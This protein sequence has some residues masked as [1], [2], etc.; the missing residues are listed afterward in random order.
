MHLSAAW[1][2]YSDVAPLHCSTAIGSAAVLLGEL[3]QLGNP[4]V[5]DTPTSYTAPMM[6]CPACGAQISADARFCSSCGT[7]LEGATDA[8]EERKVVSVLFVDLVGFTS[9]SDL[10]DPEDVRDV[11]ETY[12]AHVKERIEAFG[13]TM[14]KFIGDAVMAVFGAPLSHT[15]DAERAVRAGLK[16]L[17]AIEVLN[18]RSPVRSWRPERQ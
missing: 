4:P 6:V 10:A 15:D 17:E 2:V 7:K 1:G 13:G 9:R 16:A 14:E 8:R 3:F 5:W 11:L 18:R 12:H